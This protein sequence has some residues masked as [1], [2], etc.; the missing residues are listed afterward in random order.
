MEYLL[1]AQHIAGKREESPISKVY[2]RHSETVYRVCFTYMKNNADSED[3]ASDTFIKLMSRPQRFASEEH[4]KAWLIRTAANVC[5]DMLKQS[6]RKNVSI[7]D[8]ADTLKYT[9]GFETDSV[10]EAVL[11]LPARYK[12]A[13]YLHYY[14]GYSCVQIAKALKKPQ[15]TIRYYLHEAR[16][17]LKER[18]GS[19]YE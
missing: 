8:Y 15:S 1:C 9:A 2:R 6:A 14:E 3:A 11:E 7:S 12:A 17:M 16:K 4:E 13:V 18:L 10:S 19:D 5:K